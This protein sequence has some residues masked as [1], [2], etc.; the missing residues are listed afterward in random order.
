M[1]ANDYPD[2][3]SFLRRVPNGNGARSPRGERWQLAEDARSGQAGAR[4][5]VKERWVPELGPAG[6][7]IYDLLDSEWRQ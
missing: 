7:D 6:D 2:I 5:W 3:P 1:P 4:V